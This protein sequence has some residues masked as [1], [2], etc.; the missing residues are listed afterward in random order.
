ME[1][2]RLQEQD[3]VTALQVLHTFAGPND[4]APLAS[5]DHVRNL[6]RNDACYV[7]AA[8]ENGPCGFILAY[9]FPSFYADENTAYLYD[10]EVLPAYRKKGIGR[11]MVEQLLSLL[12]EDGVGEIWL[13]TATDNHPAQQ[14]FGTTGAQKTDETFFEY[15]YAPK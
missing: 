11:L 2:K 1:I 12:K 14:L 7:L 9:R 4:G 10:I 15:F 5:L 6:L 8:L 13:G 3:A